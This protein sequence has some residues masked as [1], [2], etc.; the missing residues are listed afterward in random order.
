MGRSRGLQQG[1][2]SSMSTREAQ[3]GHLE[4]DQSGLAHERNS[5]NDEMLLLL[6]FSALCP[7]LASVAGFPQTP[8][9]LGDRG[10]L[11]LLYYVCIVPPLSGGTGSAAIPNWRCIHAPPQLRHTGSDRSL[12]P[13]GHVGSPVL[14]GLYPQ[15][16]RHNA[17]R[18]VDPS[19]GEGFRSRSRSKLQ[20]VYIS[21]SAHSP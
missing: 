20:F 11:P 2:K 14:V 15:P 17:R 21:T 10:T 4:E 13:T 1:R 18:S 8:G 19:L 3:D 5:S 6:A 9:L 7:G 12:A 16:V